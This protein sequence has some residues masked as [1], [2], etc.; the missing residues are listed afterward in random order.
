[1]LLKVRECISLLMAS[2][3]PLDSRFYGKILSIDGAV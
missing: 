1:V 3:K 2:G